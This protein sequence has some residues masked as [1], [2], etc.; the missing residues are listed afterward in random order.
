V[1]S[2]NFIFPKNTKNGTFYQGLPGDLHCAYFRYF[3]KTG[4][5]G[6]PWFFIYTPEQYHSFF[7]TPSIQAQLARPLEAQADMDYQLKCKIYVEAGFNVLPR[8]DK[9]TGFEKVRAY[10]DDKFGTRY[11]MEFNQLFRAP[12]EELNPLP[13]EFLQIV[14]VI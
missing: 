5:P 10:Y 6:V 11:G 2:G 14:P 4:R 8:N 3:L 1:L 9:Y 12:L 7:L 13:T